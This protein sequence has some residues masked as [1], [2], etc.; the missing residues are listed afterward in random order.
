MWFVTSVW[1]TL[2][3]EWNK[4][5]LHFYFYMFYCGNKT[6]IYDWKTEV[7]KIKKMRKHSN[8]ICV[9]KKFLDFR[10]C[11]LDFMSNIVKCCN[12]VGVFF[13]LACKKKGYLIWG[14]VKTWNFHFENIRITFV[15]LF[16][17]NT[18][19]IDRKTC[20]EST[21]GNPL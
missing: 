21:K 12:E 2:F 5:I 9:K 16:L 20:V 8:E 18:L 10:P 3:G 14:I 17:H 1:A 15:F 19:K 4:N 7:K 13:A 11:W 6:K